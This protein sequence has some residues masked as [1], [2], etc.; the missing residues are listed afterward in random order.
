MGGCPPAN[1]E[2]R[3]VVARGK[4][5]KQARGNESVIATLSEAKGKQ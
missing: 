3:Y 1:H 2:N 4:A 5:P